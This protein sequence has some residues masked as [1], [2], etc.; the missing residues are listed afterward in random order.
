MQQR[1]STDKI[2]IKRKRKNILD[3]QTDIITRPESDFS[4]IDRRREKETRTQYRDRERYLRVVEK[5][6]GIVCN[7]SGYSMVLILDGSSEHD[8]QI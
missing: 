3:R 8:A 6:W 7:D 4:E 1:L 2:E 5:P